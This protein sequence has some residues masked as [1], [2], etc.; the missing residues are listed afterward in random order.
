VPSVREATVS[1]AELTDL[2]ADAADAGLLDDPAP[3]TGGPICCDMGDTNVVLT[4]A[5]TIHELSASGL[6]AEDSANLT[7]AQR[8]VRQAII[9]LRS[10]LETLAEESDDE[11]TPAELAVYVFEGGAAPG[12]EPPP[13]PLDDPLAEG[14]TPIE[15]DGR[16]LHITTDSDT[17]WA[18]VQDRDRSP[19]AAST[20]WRSAG[21][22]WH[23][24]VRPLLPHEHGCP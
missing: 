4:D 2:F 20:I 14:G 6:E 10:R 16:C 1:R 5:T 8:D 23:V 7:A 21:R 9:D 19:Q 3:D 17:V 12:V 11:Y 15:P 13:W 18:A 24:I 22:T